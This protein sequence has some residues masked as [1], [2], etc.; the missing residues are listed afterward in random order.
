MAVS[1]EVPDLGADMAG[2]VVAE[3]YLPDGTAVD[4][5]DV[6]CRVECDFVAV[7]VEAERPGVLRHQKPAGSIERPGAVLGLILSPG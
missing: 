1:V 7:E 6:V 4:S 5:G 2:G 3:W